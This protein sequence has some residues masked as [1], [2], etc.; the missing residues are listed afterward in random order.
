VT[1]LRMSCSS[2]RIS[3][4]S[5]RSL[6]AAVWAILNMSD[7]QDECWKIARNESRLCRILYRLDVASCAQI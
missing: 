2:Y 6:A 7:D 3:K 1:L 4:S 5:V